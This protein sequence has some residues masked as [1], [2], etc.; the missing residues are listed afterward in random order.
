MEQPR[1]VTEYYITPSL[2]THGARHSHTRGGRPFPHT[3][4]RTV[5]SAGRG[6]GCTRWYKERETAHGARGSPLCIRVLALGRRHIPASVVPTL[7]AGLSLLRRAHTPGCS[8]PPVVSTWLTPS[9][10]ITH[11]HAFIHTAASGA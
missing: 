7:H 5:H 11:R 6:L 4:T 3:L 9:P 1:C 2:H 10:Q 8:A